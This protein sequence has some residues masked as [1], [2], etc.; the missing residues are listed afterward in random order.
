MKKWQ[1]KKNK[2][3]KGLVFT[4]TAAGSHPEWEKNGT[5]GVYLQDVESDL[6]IQ[7]QFSS[8]V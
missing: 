3:S 1:V 2:K 5:K 8:A 6:F 7:E 4:K